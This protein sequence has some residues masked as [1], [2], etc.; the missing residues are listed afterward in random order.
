MKR[1][2]A[3]LLALLLLPDLSAK[4][5]DAFI[6][7]VNDEWERRNHGDLFEVSY[8]FTNQ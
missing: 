6:Q 8:L 7:R 4:N 2:T 3:L 5:K 1:R